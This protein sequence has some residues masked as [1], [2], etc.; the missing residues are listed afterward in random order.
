MGKCDVE[1][2]RRGAKKRMGA[3]AYNA[4]GVRQYT[5]D[6]K[7]VAEYASMADAQRATGTRIQDI[8][9][10][11]RGRYKKTHGYRWEFLDGVKNR[12]C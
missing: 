12:V 4:R 3:N 8:R 10:C 11:C 6:G 5:I 1:A 9:D 2:V 7:V